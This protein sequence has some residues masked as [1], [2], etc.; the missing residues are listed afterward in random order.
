MKNTAE[1]EKVIVEYLKN[2]TRGC[3]TKSILKFISLRTCELGKGMLNKAIWVIY[4]Y[5]LRL[6]CS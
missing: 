5:P 4:I 3:K 1:T 6:Q 2:D